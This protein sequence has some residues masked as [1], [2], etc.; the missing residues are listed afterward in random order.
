MIGGIT[1]L[2]TLRIPPDVGGPNLGCG[3]RLLLPLAL[4][5]GPLGVET[6]GGLKGP[7]SLLPSV[8]TLPVIGHKMLLFSFTTLL[9]FEYKED[10]DE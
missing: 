3:W 7:L 8:M 1:T 2:G 6:G 5:A 10:G 4:F 9:L